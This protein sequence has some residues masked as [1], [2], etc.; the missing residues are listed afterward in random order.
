MLIRKHGLIK[1]DMMGKLPQSPNIRFQ[2]REGSLTLAM[3]VQISQL[4]VAQGKGNGLLINLH[5]K[6]DWRQLNNNISLDRE[7]KLLG[8]L[9]PCDIYKTKG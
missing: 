6:N 9:Q 8:F 5:V 1:A 2:D 3:Y 4:A 7:E